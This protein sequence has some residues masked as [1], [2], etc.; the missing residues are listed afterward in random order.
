MNAHQE[1]SMLAESRSRRTMAG[2][3]L[4]E[5]L[6]GIGLGLL[7]TLVIIQVWGVFEGQRDRTSGGATAQETGLIAITQLEQS[8]HNAGSGMNAGMFQCVQINSVYDNGGSNY[9]TP[10]PGL[11]A[12]NSTPAP[13]V[14][15]DGGAT[16]SDTLQITRAT[17][18]GGAMDSTVTKQDPQQNAVINL[19]NVNNFTAVPNPCTAADK[20]GSLVVCRHH[21][22]NRCIVMQATSLLQSALKLNMNKGQCGPYNGNATCFNSGAC[23]TWPIITTGDTC[24]SVGSFVTETYSI[25]NSQ[26][27]QVVT[28]VGANTT[29]TILADNIVSLQAQYGVAP[30]GSQTVNCWTNATNNSFSTCGGDNW[31]VLTPAKVNRIKAIRLVIVP[32]SPKLEGNNVTASCTT[33]GGVV[34][35]GPCAWTDSSSNK[36]PL[37]DLSGNANWQRYR[38]RPYQTI[39]PLRNVIWANV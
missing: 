5:T 25:N 10:A 9:S 30:A 20:A 19:D 2:F 27:L 34:N 33:A 22:D 28:T 37:I 26:Q 36:A 38:Y 35:N 18:I 39:I 8:I 1:F 21:A 11:P 16:G 15:T 12:T 32:R 7:V 23:S 3:T 31:A 14:I 4:I 6:V 13:V 17:N 24:F 29:T